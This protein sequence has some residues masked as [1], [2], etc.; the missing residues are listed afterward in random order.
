MFCVWISADKSHGLTDVIEADPELYP[1]FR[2]VTVKVDDCLAGT[3]TTD[4]NPDE[5]IDAEPDV[6]VTAQV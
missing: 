6:A 2:V 5:L 4:N 3:L 1:V